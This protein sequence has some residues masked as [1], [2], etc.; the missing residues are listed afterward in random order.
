MKVEDVI[1]IGA[2]PAGIAAA[3][4]L[5]RQGVDP[6][7]FEKGM[8]GGLL[9]NANLV[10]NYPG[11]PDG[12]SGNDLAALFAKQLSKYNIRIIPESVQRLDYENALF[13][14]TTNDSTYTASIVVIA[15]G[16]KPREY[17][18]IEIPEDARQ[19]IHNEIYPI[20]TAK[21]KRIAIVGAGDAAFDYALNLGKANEVMIWNRGEAVRCLQ[22]LQERASRANSITCRTNITISEITKNSGGGLRI[23]C[24]APEGPET[25]EVDFLVYAI[26]RDP[27]LDFLSSGMKNALPKLS[28]AGSCYLLGDVKS[29]RYRQTAIAVGDAIHAAMK[30]NDKLEEVTA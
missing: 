14:I 9:H 4:Q 20:L 12:I 5:R 19:F 28:K 11:F 23:H 26:G 21:E 29:G 6:L 24:M 10:E 15:T 8:I 22:L 13:T 16:T 25:F 30:I 7:V 17:T 2:G 27:Q 3:I 1:I 18:D